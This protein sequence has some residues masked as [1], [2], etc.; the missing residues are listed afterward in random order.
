[1]YTPTNTE[2]LSIF[3][4]EVLSIPALG[5]T[6]YYSIAAAGTTATEGPVVINYTLTSGDISVNGILAVLS[7][8]YTTM[9]PLNFYTTPETALE[10]TCEKEAFIHLSLHT[11][12][13][14]SDNE[15]ED[16]DMSMEEELEEEEEE[17]E[18]ARP[19]KLQQKVIVEEVDE[20]EEEG[21]DVQE[22]E[23][24]YQY[25]YEEE[26]EGAEEDEEEEEKESLA[27]KVSE[28]KRQEE[29]NRKQEMAAR[30]KAAIKANAPKEEAKPE[31][32]ED[33]Y[34][35]FKQLNGVRFKDV[36]VGEGATVTSGKNVSIRYLGK[37][38]NGHVFD[39]TGPKGA[40]LQF[41]VGAGQVVP[42]M[43]AGVIGMKVKGRR[44]IVIPAKLAYGN[45]AVADIPANSDLVFNVELVSCK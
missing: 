40:P 12:D 13:P 42:G 11:F 31:K 30:E 20:E 25:E 19:T 34:K 8:P 18:E 33:P 28:V 43:E 3:P 37:L 7:P 45:K 5:E 2:S 10:L 14:Y 24:E 35:D 27:S 32:K 15:E 38:L 17:L 29:R 21:D 6:I 4:G 9:V 23:Y 39:K 44:T 26:E 41:R 22:Y 1:M 16:V 36:K